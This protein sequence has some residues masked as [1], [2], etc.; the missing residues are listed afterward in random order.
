MEEEEVEGEGG[1]GESESRRFDEAHRVESQRH[2]RG[3]SENMDFFP[4]FFS[5]APL[6]RF[7]PHETATSMVLEEATAA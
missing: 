4:R 3:C 6:A 5:R 1:G 7:W 2:V